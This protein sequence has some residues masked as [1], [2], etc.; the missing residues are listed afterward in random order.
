[1]KRRPP[2]EPMDWERPS[3]RFLAYLE[4]LSDACIARDIEALDK[5]MRMRLSSHLPRA[6][7]DEMEFFR[8]AKASTMRAPLRLMRYVHQMKQLATADDETSQLPL[9]LRERDVAAPLSTESGRRR[10]FNRRPEPSE[11]ND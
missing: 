4:R 9:E 7:L 2:T 10:V 6:I 8:R 3:E 1:M 11:P 5:L